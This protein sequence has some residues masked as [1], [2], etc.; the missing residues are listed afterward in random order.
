MW[1]QSLREVFEGRRT[2]PLSPG[3][4]CCTSL[5]VAGEKGGEPSRSRLVEASDG[6]PVSITSCL[7]SV[8][9]I[10]PGTGLVEGTSRDWLEAHRQGHSS[11]RTLPGRHFCVWHHG[12]RKQGCQSPKRTC[13][14]NAPVCAAP[15]R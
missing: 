5:R 7:H 3:E 6:A 9:S 2:M 13:K 11:C 4:G 14:G 12:A 15:R 10:H 1:P 8:H